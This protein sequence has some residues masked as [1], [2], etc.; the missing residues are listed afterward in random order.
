[1]RLSTCL[2]IA[3]VFV[4]PVSGKSPLEE[5][6]SGALRGC[7][8]WVLNPS[9]WIDGPEPFILS[10][11][12][13][14]QIVRVNQVYEVNLPPEN[15]RDGNQFWRI[16]STTGAGY[17]LITSDVKPMCHIT[18]GGDADMQPAVEAVLTAPDF[19]SHWEK[20]NSTTGDE[21]VSTQFRNRKEP[22]FSMVVSRAILPGQSKD[23]LQVVATAIYK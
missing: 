4:Q 20:L 5:G 6:L 16:N 12:L 22:R 2:L 9:S 15:L 14:N 11:G 3:L 18:G 13:K 10:T 19:L 1:M 17:V 8:E 21:L 7:E 23:R